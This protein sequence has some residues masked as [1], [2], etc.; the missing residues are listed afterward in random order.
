MQK[1][2]FRNTFNPHK[3]SYYRPKTQNFPALDSKKQTD[4]GQDS[5]SPKH[6][7]PAYDFEERGSDNYNP[8]FGYR[9]TRRT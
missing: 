7:S 2:S 6:L 5:P 1:K 9:D 4:Q 8:Q 3:T